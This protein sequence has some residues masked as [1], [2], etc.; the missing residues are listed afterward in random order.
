[1][2]DNKISTAEKLDA[3]LTIRAMQDRLQLWRLAEGRFGWR[4]I[5]VFLVPIVLITMGI[6]QLARDEGIVQLMLEAKGAGA[7]FLGL[8]FM[9]LFMWNHTQRQLNALRHLVKRLERDGS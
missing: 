8:V 9:A 5:I 6:A 4:E 7:I 2:T 3:K 1:M